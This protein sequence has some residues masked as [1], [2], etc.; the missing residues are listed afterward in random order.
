MHVYMQVPQKSNHGLY[1]ENTTEFWKILKHVFNEFDGTSFDDSSLD[2]GEG[3]VRTVKEVN[4]KISYGKLGLLYISKYVIQDSELYINNF[5]L[6]F[7]C[8]LLFL[9]KF[10]AS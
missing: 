8:Y 10:W 2:T 4:V 7:H 1:F 3:S 6:Q 5:F 9:K